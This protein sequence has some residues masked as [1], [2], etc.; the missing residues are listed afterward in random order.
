M[1]EGLYIYISIFGAVGMYLLICIKNFLQLL[2][3][4]FVSTY[5]CYS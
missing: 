1:F 2:M 5:L 3:E 4:V